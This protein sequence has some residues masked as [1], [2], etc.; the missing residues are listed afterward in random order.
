LEIGTKISFSE[1]NGDRMVLYESID[2]GS[3][4]DNVIVFA[5]KVKYL[6]VRK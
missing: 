5:A 4:D 2:P 1:R 3:A 6:Y